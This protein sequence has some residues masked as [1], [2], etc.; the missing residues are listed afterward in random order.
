M[1]Q[2]SPPVHKQGTQRRLSVV[3]SDANQNPVDPTGL[4]FILTEP[5]RAVTTYTYGADPELVRDSV[6]VFHVQFTPTK[7]GLHDWSFTASGNIDATYSAEFIAEPTDIDTGWPIDDTVLPVTAD[8]TQLASAKALAVQVMW[9]LSGR[10]FGIFNVTARPCLE[11]QHHRRHHLPYAGS[12]YLLM[13]DHDQWVTSWCGC[14]GRCRL[15]GPG[16]VHLPG[17]AVQII[18]VTIADA[19]LADD[20]Y[21]LQ[22]NVLFR[23]GEHKRWPSQ[24]LSRPIGAPHTWSVQYLRGAPVPAGVDHLTGILAAELYKASVGDKCRLPRSVTNLSRN[25]VSYQVDPSVFYNQG[26]TGLTEIDSWLAAINP[27]KL[28][29]NP[30]VI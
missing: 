21:V 18:A 7:R 13:W 14:H 12:N 24:D 15:T 16:A 27:N 28:L 8:P 17:P 5:D 10:Q 25:G 22:D 3:L 30:T 20:Q 4:V 11:I 2:P 23:V 1:T 9:A 26:K 19:T 6:G 29:A